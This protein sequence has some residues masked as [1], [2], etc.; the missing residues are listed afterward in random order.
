MPEGRYTQLRLNV[1]SLRVFKDSRIHEAKLPSGE[2]KFVR[3]FDVR[4]GE[5][6]AITL[7]FDA[8][9]SLHET[10]AGQYIFL[11]VIRLDIT[12]D[13]DV[14][15]AEGGRARIKGT[16]ESSEH[17]MNEKGE[18]GPK[19]T[20]RVPPDKE[21]RLE[22]P[23]TRV[24][25]LTIYHTRYDP[26]RIEVQKGDRVR[27][28]ALAAAGTGTESG[29]NHNHGVTIDEYG[30][31][32]A[33]T[34]EAVPTPVEFTADK[35]GTFAIYCKTCWDGPFGEEHPSIRAQLVVR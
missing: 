33:A 21:V 5:T 25:P 16:A 6:T 10:G 27:I 26:A 35:E 8:E 15:P 30:I 12:H 3:G 23:G 7:D 2:L 18:V 19:E 17:A 13:A 20:H 28:D 1:T 11:P 34:S 9:K 22:E 14:V 24:I 32:V 4:A 29:F 31:N